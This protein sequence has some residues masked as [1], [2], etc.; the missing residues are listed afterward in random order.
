M[1]CSRKVSPFNQRFLSQLAAAAPR[2][3]YPRWLYREQSYWTPVDVP[4]GTWRRCLMKKA[5]SK[6]AA[7]GSQWN[8][9]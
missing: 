1:S 3:R 2:G 7:L 4:N 8:R 5:W 9:C 6:F